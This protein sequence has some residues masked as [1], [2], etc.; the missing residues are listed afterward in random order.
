MSPPPKKQQKQLTQKEHNPRQIQITCSGVLF[1]THAIMPLNS[2]NHTTSSTHLSRF[3]SRM[4][5]IGRGK[6]RRHLRIRSAP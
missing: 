1:L 5:L 2:I 6:E 4:R 3:K